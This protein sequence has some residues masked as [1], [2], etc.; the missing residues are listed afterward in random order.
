MNMERRQEAML[1]R[2]KRKTMSKSIIYVMIASLL[3]ETP[4]Y[5]YALPVNFKDCQ[6]NTSNASD[7]NDVFS[8]KCYQMEQAINEMESQLHK[9]PGDTKLQRRLSKAKS[10]YSSA[11]NYYLYAQN[12]TNNPLEAPTAG[13]STLASAMNTSSYWIKA[14][15][16]CANDCLLLDAKADYFYGYY[17]LDSK[18][19]DIVNTALSLKGKIS[20]EWGVKPANKGWN[21]RWNVSG[22]GLDCSGFVAWA[23]WTGLDSD[24]FDQD[25]LSTL[26]ISHNV[27]KINY[28]ELLPGDLGMILDDGTY[29]TDINGNRF[30]SEAEAIESNKDYKQK[31]EKELL[32]EAI[33]KAKAKAK[34]KGKPFNKEKFVNSVTITSGI[35]INNVTVH[36][37]HVG[38]YVGKSKTGEDIWCHCKGGT[39]RTVVVDHYPNFHFYYRH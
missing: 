33:R 36:S 34:K 15:Y 22:T 6:L 37:N 2:L 10:L 27:Q 31:T 20:Y 13:Y 24:T 3:I 5:A 14:S 29:Y 11:C 17:N 30:Y 39:E 18:R 38:I 25:L 16:Q 1:M 32:H 9:Y 8:M 28:D 23:Y 26:S 7:K 35:D 4:M 21:E 12:I 19:K